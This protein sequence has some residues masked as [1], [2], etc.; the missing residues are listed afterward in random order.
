MDSDLVESNVGSFARP[1]FPPGLW[2]GLGEGLFDGAERETAEE[3]VSFR[4]VTH[5]I[6]LSITGFINAELS[7]S[8]LIALAIAVRQLTKVSPN[9]STFLK[10]V[11]DS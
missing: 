9:S 10:F 6:A 1:R 11:T 2:E 8:K 7:P 3:R 5:S 4:D